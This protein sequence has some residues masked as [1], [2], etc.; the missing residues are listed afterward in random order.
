MVNGRPS[1]ATESI[2]PIIIPARAI[3]IT[4]ESGLSHSISQTEDLVS[5]SSVDLDEDGIGQWYHHPQLD[6]DSGS[7][8]DADLSQDNVV[9]DSEA[10]DPDDLQNEHSGNPDNLIHQ[11]DAFNADSSNIRPNESCPD[12]ERGPKPKDPI[13][14]FCPSAHR[15]AILRLFAK[16][17]SLHSLLPERHG[18]LRTAMEI[19]RDSVFEMY[20]HCWLNNL[21]EVWAYLWSQWYSP[22]RWKLWTRSSYSRSIPCKRTTMIVESLWRN[23]KRIYMPL[24]NRPPVDLTTR[25]LVTQLTPQYRLSLA[26]LLQTQ[27][28]GRPQAPGHFQEALKKSWTRLLAIPIKGSYVT[29]VLR[30]TCDCGSQKYHSYLLCKHLVQ[31]ANHDISNRWWTTVIRYHI[32]P[33]YLIPVDGLLPEPPESRFNHGWHV[34]MG[35]GPSRIINTN[36]EIDRFDLPPSSP[37]THFDE[38]DIENIP[39]ELPI[40]SS[41]PRNLAGVDELS[42]T[43][44]DDGGENEVR[45]LQ[46]VLRR[47]MHNTENLHKGREREDQ[48]RVSEADERPP[49]RPGS[50]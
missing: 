19:R 4:S 26:L 5:N 20:T 15:L 47:A 39:P 33:F 18:K 42:F 22:D 7:E 23:L 29:D 17:A 41:P 9:F 50:R 21:S 44:V 27:R 3:P 11:V 1:V 36:T 25:V 13:Y 40:T 30:W 8:I 31:A 14:Q 32:Q 35:L 2:L 43:R 38:S 24:Y 16:H 37:P 34:R 12:S 28:S 46:C 10:E 45:V 49:M 6:E 48:S